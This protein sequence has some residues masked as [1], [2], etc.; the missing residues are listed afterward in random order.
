MKNSATS[1]NP[2]PLITQTVES[3]EHGF[4]MIVASDD[5]TH[6][7][8]KQRCH[9][10]NLGMTAFKI[11]HKSIHCNTDENHLRESLHTCELTNSSTLNDYKAHELRNI[12]NIM[13]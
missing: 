7:G 2:L 9:S 10:C 4:K 3:N 8:R 5:H 11:Y 13:G 1:E 12:L 6:K